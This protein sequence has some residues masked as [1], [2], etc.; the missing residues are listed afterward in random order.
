VATATGGSAEFLVD[1]VNCLRYPA[2]DAGALAEAVRLLA[3]DA[4]LRA[5][6]VTGGLV[7]AAQLGVDAL[8]S[9]LEDWHV[10]AASRYPTGPPPHRRLDGAR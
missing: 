1:G 6:L 9:T 10:A 7:T 4:A 3:A 2:G 5:R 8:A